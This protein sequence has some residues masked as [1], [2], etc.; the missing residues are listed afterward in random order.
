METKAKEQ[1]LS[2]KIEKDIDIM[3]IDNT[4]ITALEGGS[5]YWYSINDNDIDKLEKWLDKK[6]VRNENLHYKFIDALLQE[7]SNKL[8][9]YDLEEVEGLDL[10]DFNNQIEELYD[11]LTPLGYLCLGTILEGLKSAYINN[12][13]E[14]EMELGDDY[15]GDS[16]TADIIFQ[17]FIMGDVVYG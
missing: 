10:E 4:I 3:K 1:T 15:A 11:S 14:Y 6:G 17:H 13:E 9:I 2:L 7:K 8:P 5:N 12:N 16:V